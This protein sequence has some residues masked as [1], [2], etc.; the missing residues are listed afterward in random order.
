M[1]RLHHPPI[2]R[3]GIVRYEKRSLGLGTDALRRTA[4]L[5]NAGFWNSISADGRS[6][7]PRIRHHVDLSGTRDTTAA[8]GGTTTNKGK[9]LVVPCFSQFSCFV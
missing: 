6:V 2:R 1:V 5:A 7:Q 4:W 9:E 3:C 8:A